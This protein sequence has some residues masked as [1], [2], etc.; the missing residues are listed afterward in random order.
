MWNSH[1]YDRRAGLELDFYLPRFLGGKLAILVV[2]LLLYLCI[3]YQL[4]RHMN[5]I[6]VDLGV[7]HAEA[8]AMLAVLGGAD[9][10]VTITIGHKDYD[11]TRHMVAHGRMFMTCWRAVL[12]QIE[13]GTIL[14]CAL[15]FV[16]P[17][18]WQGIVVLSDLGSPPLLKPRPAERQQQALADYYVAAPAPPQVVP[19]SRSDETLEETD[20][21]VDRDAADALASPSPEVRKRPR[22]AKKISP[23][24]EESTPPPTP[25]SPPIVEPGQV[26]KRRKPEG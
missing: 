10:I 12:W 23:P 8:A 25:P 14:A 1:D 16:P 15:T 5:P 19:S 6:A 20:R 3:S 7:A 13:C 26:R 9:T 21:T 22:K 11:L 2:I 17:V 24:E 18:L 4:A